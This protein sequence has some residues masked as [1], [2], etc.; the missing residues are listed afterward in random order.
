VL[1]V[2]GILSMHMGR[3]EVLA[4]EPRSRTVAMRAPPARN[5]RRCSFR[6]QPD[7]KL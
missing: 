1:T 2:G 7:R 3:H 6:R 4:L 5:P